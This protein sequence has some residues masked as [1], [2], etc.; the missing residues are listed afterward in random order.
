MAARLSLVRRI[1]RNSVFS[2]VDQAFTLLFGLIFTVLLA[3]Y[4]GPETLGRYSVAI[5]LASII[6]AIASLGVQITVKRSIARKPINASFY[7]RQ[8]MIIRLFLT[9]PVSLLICMLLI[10]TLGYDISD[11]WLMLSTT[12]YVFCTGI[13]LLISGVLTSM[14]RNDTV[15]YVNLANK[16]IL[17]LGLYGG[18]V[19]SM[20]I[21]PLMQLIA[22]LSVLIVALATWVTG[23]MVR[24]V[25]RGDMPFS[26]K[27]Y[28]R[29]LILTSAPLSL[30]MIA[31]YINLK[32][33][34]VLLSVLDSDTSVGLYA[35]AFHILLAFISLPLALIR[36]FFPNFVEILISNSVPAIK[37]TMGIYIAGFLLYAFITIVVV[38]PSSD[39]IVA[40]LYGERFL[41]SSGILI[42]LI[43]GLPV[44]VLNRLFN[45][46]I[47]AMKRNQEFLVITLIGAM[48]N[49]SLNFLLI[50]I[51]SVY[52]AAIATV[53][54]EA[55][56]LVGGLAVARKQLHEITT[57]SV[58]V[59]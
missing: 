36:V 38:I 48:V 16:P 40:Q 4:Y 5:S 26:R 18:L 2:I 11:S 8:A 51:Y 43:V 13:L 54:S 37:Q 45:Y 31:E 58:R 19:A 9:L 29:R 28:L 3:R 41:L 50:P 55:C 10:A 47:V 35:A 12:L 53:I 22:L 7:F 42:Y 49:I 34:T 39:W 17:I 52:G 56:V 1:L 44:I 24:T 25:S 33:D 30:V 6:S 32:I 59:D 27:V 14:H 20:G 21:E 46:V 15:L 57:R 23:R